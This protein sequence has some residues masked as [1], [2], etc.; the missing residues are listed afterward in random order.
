MGIAIIGN[1]ANKTNRRL[2]AEWRNL[3]LDVELVSGG[4]GALARGGTRTTTTAIGRIDVLATLDGVEPGLLELLLLERSGRLTTLNGAAALL[5]THDKLR[6]SSA[7][8]RGGVPHPRTGYVRA[9]DAPLPVQPPL[10]IKPRFGSWGLEVHRCLDE[11]ETRETLRALAETP[12]F[13]RHGALVQELLPTPRY[14]LRVVVAGDRVVG[15]AERRAAPG[16][17]R[18]NVSLGGTRHA[19]IPSVAACTLAV[20]AAQ[21]VG[22]HLVGVDLLPVSATR[23]IVLE[24]NGAVE[25][26]EGYCL[27]GRDVFADA[28]AAL[29]LGRR[30]PAT[31]GTRRPRT[32]Q[33]APAPLRPG[34]R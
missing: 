25:F 34:D 2:V 9:P 28:A 24:L 11:V 30:E 16:E 15:A 31:L 21:A 7:L 23:Y 5:G 33:A 32:V 17:W 19:T 8:A 6:T 13:L 29:R 3:G 20:R 26:D 18:T 1:A 14:D 4:H 22:C 10:V 27:P 12:W